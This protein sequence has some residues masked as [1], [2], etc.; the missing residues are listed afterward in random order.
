MGSQEKCRQRFDLVN[1]LKLGRINEMCA[2]IVG[3]KRPIIPKNK[4]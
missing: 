4:V 2:D 3:M 1:P